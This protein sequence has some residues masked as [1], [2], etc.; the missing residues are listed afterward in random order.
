MPELRLFLPIGKV[1]VAQRLVYARSDALPVSS[2]HGRRLLSSCAPKAQIR[3]E[4]PTHNPA[5]KNVCLI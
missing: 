2:V 1:D 4:I 5:H 3:R